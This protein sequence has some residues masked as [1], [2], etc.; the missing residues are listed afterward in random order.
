MVFAHRLNITCA[1]CGSRLMEWDTVSPWVYFYMCL[2]YSRS[3]DPYQ[4]Q[5]GIAVRLST[6]TI[7]LRL[8]LIIIGC[9]S[10]LGLTSS[11]EWKYDPR[12][13]VSGFNL[14]ANLPLKINFQRRLGLPVASR[15][16]EVAS[17][18]VCLKKYVRHGKIHKFCKSSRIKRSI[19]L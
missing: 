19:T 6:G 9:E 5:I 14:L 12:C 4:V 18:F 3:I 10:L 13:P 15:N 7:K 11:L 8:D 2:Y 17:N 16:V 1:R